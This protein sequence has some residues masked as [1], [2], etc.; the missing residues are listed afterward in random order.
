MSLHNIQIQS[1]DA[2]NFSATPV[3]LIS[4]ILVILG[5]VLLI[6]NGGPP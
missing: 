4:I 5:I 6:G 2:V 1:I 3:R